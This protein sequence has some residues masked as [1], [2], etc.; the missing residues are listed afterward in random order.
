MAALNLFLILFINNLIFFTFTKEETQRSIFDETYLKHLKLKNRIF[1][2]AVGDTTF[3]NGK[4]SE[5][6][7][8]LY[9]QLSKNEVGTIFTGFTIVSDYNQINGV[10]TFRMDKD[11]YCAEYKKIS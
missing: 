8:K 4:I 2:A 11:E 7:F 3:K 1:R 9:D 5:E 6:G 10:G